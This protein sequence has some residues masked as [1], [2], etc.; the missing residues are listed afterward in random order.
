MG[1]YTDCMLSIEWN[2]TQ[3]KGDTAGL[4]SLLRLDSNR[5]LNCRG[6]D[7]A[8]KHLGGGVLELVKG[9]H[10][11]TCGACGHSYILTIIT[12]IM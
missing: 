8:S 2:L 9:L 7:R 1:T 6:G 11:G 10:E 4:R 5:Q 3:D 12:E